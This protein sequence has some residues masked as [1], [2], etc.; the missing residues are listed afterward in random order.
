MK[1]SGI[2]LGATT[3]VCF[4]PSPGATPS[5]ASWNLRAE[6][7]ALRGLKL[8]AALNKHIADFGPDVI[9]VEAPMALAGVA[10][11]GA[12]ADVLLSLYGYDMLIR[13][14]AESRGVRVEDVDVQKARYHFLGF[15]PKSGEGKKAVAHRCK[16]L[17]WRPD[18]H[19]ESDAAAVW[20]YGVQ[21]EKPAAQIAL[22]LATENRAG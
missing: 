17:G 2:D 18:N 10:K 6:S 8:M 20:D 9:Y 1:V 16:A 15:K 19:N 11:V 21:N 4:G 3:G 12:S 5:F 22:Q 14:V 13:V 7:R